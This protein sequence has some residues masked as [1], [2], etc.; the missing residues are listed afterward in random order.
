M[1]TTYNEG[2]ASS[3]V[4]TKQEVQP[5]G[6]SQIVVDVPEFKVTGSEF[7]YTTSNGTSYNAAYREPA[8]EIRPISQYNTAT[9]RARV[10]SSGNLVYGARHRNENYDEFGASTADTRTLVQGATYII[11]GPVTGTRPRFPIPYFP[12]DSVG[13]TIV[14]EGQRRTILKVNN[15]STDADGNPRLVRL[16]TITITADGGTPANGTY[17]SAAVQPSSTQGS[18]S[19]IYVRLRLVQTAFGQSIFP[20]I[21][22]AGQNYDPQTTLQFSAAS[23][24]QAFTGV[25]GLTSPIGASGPL[26]LSFE[27]AY[28]PYITI[29][30]P[31]D[32]P[33][34]V[35]KEQPALQPNEETKEQSA[36]IALNELTS[37]PLTEIQTLTQGINQGGG[38][39]RPTAIYHNTITGETQRTPPDDFQVHSKN[40]IP[41]LAKEA[42]TYLI[43]ERRRTAF[44]SL[45]IGGTIDFQ[46]K[47]MRNIV[48]V[49]GNTSRT[50]GITDA[51][52]LTTDFGYYPDNPPGSTAQ[53]V[54]QTDKR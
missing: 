14:V 51:N 9:G 4:T 29:N 52:T 7:W 17:V 44:N 19:G 21:I 33:I 43:Q 54:A 40:T 6:L 36:W 49:G 12:A 27:T 30:K 20:L 13:K 45:M 48:S 53:T 26:I 23:I 47:G 31:F 39:V 37:E 35:F 1:T 38:Q 22:S 8:L 34:T 5:Y 46:G 11:P 28:D 32:P 41:Q 3:L 50:A 10:E 15:L 25:N 18:G 24:E 16:N 2:T 42:P